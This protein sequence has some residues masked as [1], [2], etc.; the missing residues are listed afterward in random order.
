MSGQIGGKLKTLRERGGDMKLAR[1][2][3][4]GLRV[5]GMAKLLLLFEI[6]D[7]TADAVR[8]FDFKVR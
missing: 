5:F 6:F 8:S 3:T 1:L 4:R 7:T 2:N